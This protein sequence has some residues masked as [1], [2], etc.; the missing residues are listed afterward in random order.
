MSDV[1][2]VNSTTDPPKLTAILKL[3]KEI[4]ILETST[5]R[6]HKK[7]KLIKFKESRSCALEKCLQM[8]SV[9]RLRHPRDING[10]GMNGG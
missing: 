10:A 6:E 5:A 2:K 8:L 4:S 1:L 3:T 7:N 9:G